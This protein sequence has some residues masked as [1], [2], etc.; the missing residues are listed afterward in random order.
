MTA[1]NRPGRTRRTTPT[2]V[3]ESQREL[4]DLAF[5]LALL[6]TA[7]K[8]GS[9]SLIFETPESSLDG[10]AMEQVGGALADFANHGDNRLIVT[11]NLTNVQMISAIFGG[12]AD[13]ERTL[14]QRY[15]RTLNLLEEAMP[16][17][18]VVANRARYEKIIAQSLRGTE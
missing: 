10:V 12:P 1:A 6:S 17:R 3:S 14:C 9:G 11:S 2:D 13:S 16:N 7:T 15:V 4:V 18:A 5:R 8:H